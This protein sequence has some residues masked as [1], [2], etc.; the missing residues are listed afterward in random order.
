MVYGLT[1][2]L[3]INKNITLLGNGATLSGQGSTRIM[4]IDGGTVEIFDTVFT[5]GN[6]AGTT[7]T[8]GSGNSG[9]GGAVMVY[10]QNSSANVSFFTDS[11]IGN[12]GTG[13]GAIMNISISRWRQLDPD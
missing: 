1:T 12:S 11:F 2:Q 5:G 4:E 7:G 3:L 9:Y 8:S 10:T 13:G 6:G